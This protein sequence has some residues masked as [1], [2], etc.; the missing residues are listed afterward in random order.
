MLSGMPATMP[1]QNQIR[2]IQFYQNDAGE[3]PGGDGRTGREKVDVVLMDP[4]QKRQR[5][6]NS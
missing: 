6:K 3:I 2:N 4:P 5:P 1:R